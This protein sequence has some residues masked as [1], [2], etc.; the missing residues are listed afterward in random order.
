MKLETTYEDVLRVAKKYPYAKNALEELYPEVFYEPI[1]ES[2]WLTSEINR[3]ERPVPMSLPY[4]FTVISKSDK[5][6]SIKL[7]YPEL[8]NG[9]NNFGNTESVTI[10]WDIVSP[11]GYASFLEKIKSATLHVGLIRVTSSNHNQLL[12]KY[13]I[14]DTDPMKTGI[15]YPISLFAKSAL[16][17]AEKFSNTVE[18]RID[19]FFYEG[20]GIAYTQL[21]NTEISFSMFPLSDVKLTRGDAPSKVYRELGRPQVNINRLRQ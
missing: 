4:K 15:I 8:N 6:E 18:Q 13:N 7:L 9:S 17:D 14:F 2:D 12:E 5:S 19:Q 21:P 1:D 3:Q 20:T 16:S 10:R 11:W